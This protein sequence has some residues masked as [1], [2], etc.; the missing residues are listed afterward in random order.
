MYIWIGIIIAAVITGILEWKSLLQQGKTKD[1][2]VALSILTLGTT[3]YLF[4]LFE[5][6]MPTLSQ[7][8]SKGI[9]PL[10]KPVARW[11]MEDIDN[12]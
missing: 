11:I 5:V 12:G 10:Y 6:P 2:V 3:L 1:L 9:E 8:L 4:L 7:L